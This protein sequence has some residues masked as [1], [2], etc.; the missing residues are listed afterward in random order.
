[1]NKYYRSY[2]TDVNVKP[3]Y[4]AQLPIPEI[5][6]KQQLPFITLVDKILTIKKSNPVADTTALEEKIDKLVFDLYGLTDEE[7][8]IVIGG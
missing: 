4:L 1:M 8:K 7:R 5:K 3:T 2:Y 6:S